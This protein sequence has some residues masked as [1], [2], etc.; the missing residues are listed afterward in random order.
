MDQVTIAGLPVSRFILGSNPFSGFSHQGPDRDL[1]MRHYFTTAR[2]KQTIRQAERLGVNALVGRADHH[3][4]RVLLE[5]WDEG[6][7][8]QWLAQTCPE[9][10]SHEA[11]VT[12]AA[13][14]GARACHVHGGVMDHLLAQG[15]Q[16]EIPPVLRMIRDRGMPA[17][18]AGHDPKVFEWAEEY[19][20]ADYYL[21]SYYNSA[22]RDER[23]ELVSGTREWFLEE[24]RRIMTE[25]IRGLS[26][27][28]IHYKVMAAGRNDPR[29]AFARVAE[30]LRPGDAVCVGVYPEHRPVMLR[31][32]VRLFEAAV[33]AQGG[34]PAPR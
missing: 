20:D 33:A 11:C 10:G 15:K 9:V 23:A 6:G 26:R 4:M 1:A 27:P 30:C 14:G 34:N 19:V 28:V 8:V 12:R 2:I 16:D 17:G 32:D 25:R 18:I 3:I 22:H 13:E 24:D 7:T 21:C 31:E 29:E 5:Y